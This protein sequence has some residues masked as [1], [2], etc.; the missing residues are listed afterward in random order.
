M[1]AYLFDMGNVLVAF[2]HWRF[3]RRLAKETNRQTPDEIYTLVFQKG[4]NTRFELG[5]LKGKNFYQEMKKELGFSLSIE[6]VRELW[7]DIFWENTGMAELLQ[8]LHTRARLILI[9]NTNSWHMD[10]IKEQFNIL[11]HF[12]TLILS[13][14]I[15]ICKP[16]E[17]IFKAAL[18]AAK[19]SPNNC[20]F[21]DDSEFN[22]QAA[23]KLGIPSVLFRYDGPCPD[24]R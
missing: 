23:R 18:S 10:Y 17:R 16:D 5:Q 21:F 19:T 13:Y 20:L 15:G 11:S 3:C 2:D 4:L 14:E 9:S 6:R 1:D 24:S 12:H 8:A 7:C 22:V